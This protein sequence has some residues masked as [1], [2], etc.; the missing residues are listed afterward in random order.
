MHTP[1]CRH[2]ALVERERG[3]TAKVRGINS[4]FAVETWPPTSL[5]Y[6]Y[7]PVMGR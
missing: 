7:R 2:R 1:S 3:G 4:L 5:G 6:P